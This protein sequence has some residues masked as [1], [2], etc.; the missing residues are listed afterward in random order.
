M[1]KVTSFG[2]ELTKAIYDLTNQLSKVLDG[3]SNEKMSSNCFS[4]TRKK[5][6]VGNDDEDTNIKK[7]D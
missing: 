4:S 6:N 3:K 1:A 5:G 7:M 2:D